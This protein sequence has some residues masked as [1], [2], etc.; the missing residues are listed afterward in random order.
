MEVL[1]AVTN[2]QLQGA[3][4]FGIAACSA[5]V[6]FHLILKN[7]RHRILLLAF[8][9]VGIIVAMVGIALESTVCFVLGS[10]IFFF[11]VIA[12]IV[13]LATEPMPKKTLR[14]SRL[15]EV[16]RGRRKGIVALAGLA[17]VILGAGVAIGLLVGNSS[18]SAQATPPP[19]VVEGKYHVSGTCANGSCT[20]NECEHRAACG[21][22]NQGRLREGTTLDIV[23]QAGGKLVEAPNGRKSR[24]WDRLSDSLYVSDLFVSGTKVGRFAP[25]LPRCTGGG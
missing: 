14:G 15:S 3:V 7:H 23:C 11:T 8:S 6:P 19:I 18:D 12:A 9:F 20:L 13:I 17:L 22:E 2:T 10:A 16:I 1:G 24:I 5:L 4:G 25:E 21:S